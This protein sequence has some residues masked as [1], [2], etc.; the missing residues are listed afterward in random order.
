MSAKFPRGGGANPYSAIRLLLL[1]WGDLLS[2][3]DIF[4]EY[5]KSCIEC[6]GFG[7]LSS[8]IEVLKN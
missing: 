5:H 4:Q 3:I 6:D 8:W 7:M 1:G 2:L